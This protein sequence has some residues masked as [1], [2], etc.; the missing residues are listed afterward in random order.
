MQNLK[1]TLVQ[2]NQLWENKT[3]NLAN[4][5]RLLEKIPP[6]DLIVFP[7]MF[8]TGFTM[9]GKELSEKMEDSIGLNWLI[10][11]AKKHQAACYTSLIIEE[12][13]RFFNRGIFVFPDGTFKSYDKRKRFAMAGENK[14][15]EAGEKEQIVHYLGWKIN[16]QIC[17][18][19]R[20]PENIRNGIESDEPCYDLLLY[21]ANWPEKRIDHW[22]TL[23]K[24][25]AI[26]NQGI[27]I[28]VNRVGID[29]NEHN[30]TGESTCF[31]ADGS[32]LIRCEKSKEGIETVELSS[33]ILNSIRLQ[34]PF[35]TDSN[36]R[37]FDK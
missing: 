3:G 8:H 24:A 28:G 6:T 20:F 36:Y 4:Y 32:E 13:S 31:G 12:N 26:E 17:Y 27:V 14:V 25:R 30:Y 16:L 11:T 33:S 9:N 15:Y 37:S 35:L 29:G 22:N 10:N 23:L 7:E 5:D 18:D 19:L 1:V 21:V 34:L 2:A